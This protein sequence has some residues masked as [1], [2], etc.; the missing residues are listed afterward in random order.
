MG[1]H[2]AKSSSPTAQ[3]RHRSDSGKLLYL[4]KWSQL[5]I[6][7]SIQELKH[8]MT[9]P[10]PNC[11]KGMERVMQHVL[12]MPKRGLVMQLDDMGM[13]VKSISSKLTE[14]LIWGM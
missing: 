6:M 10:Y 14:F 12:S 7:K 5:E 11:E 9:V 2:I 8:F 1:K 13:E 3:T 4:V